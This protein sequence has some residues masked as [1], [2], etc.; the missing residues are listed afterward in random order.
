MDAGITPQDLTV[1]RQQAPPPLIIDVR[2]E[3]VFRSAPDRIAGAMRQDPA[4]IGH[5]AG[6]I[7]ND[8]PVIVYCVHGHEVSQKA[9]QALRDLGLNAQFLEGGIE[10]WRATG[11]ALEANTAQP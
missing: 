4:T 5:W 2:R 7:P 11:G 1:L 10:A 3:P 9:A 8:A 6:T